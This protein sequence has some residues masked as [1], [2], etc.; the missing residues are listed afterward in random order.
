[1]T[2]RCLRTEFKPIATSE[3]SIEDANAAESGTANTS[4][5]LNEER[6]INEC[7][8]SLCETQHTNGDV[9]GTHIALEECEDDKRATARQHAAKEDGGDRDE[10][11]NDVVALWACGNNHDSNERELED[12]EE[13]KA[14]VCWGASSSPIPLLS[15]KRVLGVLAINAIYSVR[16]QHTIVGNCYRYWV[17]KSR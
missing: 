4:L 6:G 10:C 5:L 14:P 8:G 17:G 12:C 9:R 15:G 13:G 2:L 3:T 16:F 7:Y 11:G 1:M